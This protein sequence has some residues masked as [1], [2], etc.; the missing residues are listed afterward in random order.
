[1]ETGAGGWEGGELQE[2]NDGQG[3]RV[4]GVFSPLLKQLTWKFKLS[5][6]TVITA[7]KIMYFVQLHSRKIRIA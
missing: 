2:E 4:K 1:M 6:L 5:F 7:E 3:E